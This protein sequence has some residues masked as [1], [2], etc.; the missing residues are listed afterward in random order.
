MLSRK[1]LK[2]GTPEMAEYMRMIRSKKGKGLGA[3]LVNAGKTKLKELAK[4]N[5]INLVDK[6]SNIVKDKIKGMGMRSKSAK[7]LIGDIGKKV[8]KGA[9]SYVP[10]P[11]IVKDVAGYAGD[12]LI[13]KTGLGVLHVKNNK[14]NVKN[15][16]V[17]SAKGLMPAGAY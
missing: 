5:L 6:G 7:G 14:V 3:D 13:D 8:F 9:L 11:D 15:N 10:A 1:G 2:K 16:R 12:K 17:K 4:S